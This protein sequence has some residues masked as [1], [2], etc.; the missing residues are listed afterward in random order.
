MTAQ[1]DQWFPDFLTGEEDFAVRGMHPDKNVVKGVLPAIRCRVFV[2]RRGGKTSDIEELKTRADTLTLFPGQELG[3]L[4]FRSIT[5]TMDE[6]YADIAAL[7]TVFEPSALPPESAEHYHELMEQALAPPA[8]AP[9]PENVP[10]QAEYEL[11]REMESEEKESGTA[12]PAL[13]GLAALQKTVDELEAETDAIL[14]RSGMT[15]EDVE[16]FIAKTERETNAMLPTAPLPG[17]GAPSLEPLNRMVNELEEQAR[18]MLRQSGKTEEELENFLSRHRDIQEPPDL[19]K[20][21]APHL[22]DPALPDELKGHMRELLESFAKVDDMCASLAQFGG[23]KTP[24]PEKEEEPEPMPEP[25]PVPLT[26]EQ[27]LERHARGQSLSGTDLSGLDLGGADLT[28]IDLQ[29]AILH[30][31]NFSN[32]ILT[33]AILR[34]ADCSGSDFSQ[35]TMEG[36]DL[37]AAMFEKCD[38]SKARAANLLAKRTLFQEARAAGADFSGADMENADFNGAVLEAAVFSKASIPRIRLHAA[39]LKKADFSAAN[40]LNSRADAGTDATGAKFKSADM[41]LS[42]WRGATLQ[43]ADMSHARL[44]NANMGHCILR[45]ARLDH[46][47]AE[48]AKFFKA[49]LEGAHLSAANLSNS[50]LRRANLKA[51]HLETALLHGADIYQCALD[52]AAL[53]SQGLKNTIMDPEIP[54]RFK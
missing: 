8:L 25:E 4:T 29:G 45:G 37:S 28:G 46:L 9:E 17:P 20:E 27:V 43:D 19:A 47:D 18:A 2:K 6:E 32:C 1:E 16:A 24:P 38:L 34:K 39:N 22:A 7:L 30:D 52:D 42:G 15:R 36:A 23:A 40:M 49:D 50:C 12:P 5:H 13:P 48:D 33:Q 35:S 31:V 51:A 3:A 21:F 44:K 14:K 41:S 54:T 53:R 26:R 10:G 11:P